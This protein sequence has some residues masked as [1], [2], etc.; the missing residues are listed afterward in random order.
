M[1]TLLI[2]ILFEKAP[3]F[4]DIQLSGPKSEGKYLKR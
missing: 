2:G 3:Y 4:E 1:S